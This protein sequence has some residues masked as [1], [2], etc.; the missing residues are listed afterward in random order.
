MRRL[1]GWDGATQGYAIFKPD[2][3]LVGRILLTWFF[4]LI[5]IPSD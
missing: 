1:S 4:F 3:V 5:D 2:P